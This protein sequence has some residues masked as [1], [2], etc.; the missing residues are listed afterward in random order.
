MKRI[1][2]TFLVLKCS[3]IISAGEVVWF[4]GQH[5]VTYNIPKKAELVVEGCRQ[6][7]VVKD[8]SC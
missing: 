3:L 8:S 2:L 7:P 6:L 4:D 5:P 1:L